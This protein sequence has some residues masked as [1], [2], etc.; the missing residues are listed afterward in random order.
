MRVLVGALL[1]VG[2]AAPA[3]AVTGQDKVVRQ[4]DNGTA[5]SLAAGEKLTVRLKECAPCGYAWRGVAK[6]DAA[7]LKRISSRYID[8]PDDGTVGGPGT[9]V[10]VFRGVGHGSTLVGL[11]YVGPDGSVAKRF[12]LGVFVASD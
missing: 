3:S 9:R 6:P 10:I 12:R 7:V 1:A 2:L 11:R 8:P 5:V 4:K